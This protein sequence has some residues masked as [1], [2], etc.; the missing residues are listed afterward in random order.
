VVPAR[1][2]L[3][4]VEQGGVEQ[5]GGPPR[6][7]G[8]WVL[9]AV[10]AGLVLVAG[11]VLAVLLGQGGSEPTAAP[12]PA[13]APAL[14]PGGGQP[15]R[16]ASIPARVVLEPAL[17]WDRSVTGGPHG[18]TAST[19]LRFVQA[20]RAH[21]WR[22]AFRVCAPGLRAAAAERSPVLRVE[23]SVVVGA[24]FYGDALRGRTVVGGRMDGVAAAPGGDLVTFR[25]RLDDG[26]GADVVL[27]LGRGQSVEDWTR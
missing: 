14:L 16:L 20:V 3:G 5:G 2:V 15:V 12:A 8:L 17:G 18:A 13:T 25:L 23:P 24:A 22:A 21:D 10:L 7:R 1:S 4:G 9:L 26:T 19:A 27:R 11:T 6:G